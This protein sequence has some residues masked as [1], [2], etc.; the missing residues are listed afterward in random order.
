MSTPESEAKGS[1][2]NGRGTKRLLWGELGLQ[3]FQKER[4]L[5]FAP[6]VR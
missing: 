4:D 1:V 2:E 3:L 5:L 6:A